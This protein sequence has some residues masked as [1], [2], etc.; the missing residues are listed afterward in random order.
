LVYRVKKYSGE[1]GKNKIMNWVNL[2]INPTKTINSFSVKFA[3]ISGLG[4][5]KLY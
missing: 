4:K 1:I 2:S 3:I 5:L